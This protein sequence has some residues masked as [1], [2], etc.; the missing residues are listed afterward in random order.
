MTNLTVSLQLISQ[1]FKVRESPTDTGLFH[2][3]HREIRLNKNKKNLL[4]RT[5]K[6]T[7]A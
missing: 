5:L 3:E 6:E 4:M 2:A 1:P 7:V